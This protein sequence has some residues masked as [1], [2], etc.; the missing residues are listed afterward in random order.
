M[1]PWELCEMLNLAAAVERAAA[2]DIIHYE[3][4]YYPMSLAF[5][6][7]VADAD[8][9]DAAPLAERRRRS[10][11]WSR[12]PRGAVRRHLAR[13]GAPARPASTSSA[14]CCTASTP[15]PSRSAPIP[16]T[17]CCSSA[18]SPKARACCRRSRSRGGPG[19]RLMLAAAE[20][21]Y[22]REH[23]A[24]LVDGTTG[25]LRRRG[26]FTP[27]RSRCSAARARC[28]IRCRRASRSAWC[29]PKRWRA[30]RRSPRSTAAPS[31]EIVDD[32]VT[33]VVFDSTRRAGRRAAAGA[34][35]RSR[36]GCAP[37]RWS[38][39]ASTG[40]WTAT[41]PLYRGAGRRSDEGAER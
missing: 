7:P 23:V 14:P 6:R 26:R 8:R 27:T 24:P 36:G 20:N 13:A 38:A 5:T 3:A 12:Y 31:R 15:T 34:G 11:L 40:W 22:Y 33:G 32:G 39:S 41:W 1:W 30:A 18:A 28:S 37:R 35:A 25:R 2:F 9:A 4:E 29:W 16:T 19:M 17:T 10:A 21:D